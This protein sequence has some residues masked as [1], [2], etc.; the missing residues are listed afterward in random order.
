MLSLHRTLVGR[1]VTSPLKRVPRCHVHGTQQ[2]HAKSM[3]RI[4]GKVD[5]FP[6][7]LRRTGTRAT[8]IIANDRLLDSDGL[9]DGLHRGQYHLSRENLGYNE[10]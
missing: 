8:I 7:L 3:H 2:R 9:Q 6:T 1:R 4:F 10:A 5:K